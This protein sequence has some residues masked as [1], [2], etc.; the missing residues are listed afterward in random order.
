MPTNISK[1][2]KL[3]E[4]FVREFKDRVTWYTISSSQKFC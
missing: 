3:S 4:N 2:Q 1:C